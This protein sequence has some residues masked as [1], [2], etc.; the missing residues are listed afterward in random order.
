M[1]F[2]NQTYDGLR[3]LGNHVPNAHGY[4][5]GVPNYQTFKS[6]L[7]QDHPA[8]PIG[9]DDTA[10]DFSARVPPLKRNAV[11]KSRWSQCDLNAILFSRNWLE[12]RQ[13]TIG[14][15]SVWGEKSKNHGFR[16]IFRKK[17]AIECGQLPYLTSRWSIVYF[18]WRWLASY[19]SPDLSWGLANIIPT[20][21][22]EV[23][24]LE[25]LQIKG[26]RN[27]S[28][29]SNPHKHNWRTNITRRTRSMIHLVP[30]IS[31]VFYNIT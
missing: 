16:R 8:F 23:L 28:R 25:I 19:Q 29:S 3:S 18:D 27:G 1:I 20:K 31:T 13:E 5:G 12:N 14:D 6:G 9:R 21:L 30:Q 4:F 17:P 7:N 22:V 10:T 11:G 2:L 15:L 26:L 24:L